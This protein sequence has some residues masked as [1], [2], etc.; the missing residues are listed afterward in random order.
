MEPGG[1]NLVFTNVI[2]Y[3]VGGGARQAKKPLQSVHN[4]PKSLVSHHTLNADGQTSAST[5]RSHA[6][7]R[8]L[9]TAR[10]CRIRRRLSAPRSCALTSGLRSISIFTGSVS[11]VRPSRRD[12]RCT[13]GSTGRP[14]SSMATLRTTLA[15]LRPTPGRVT[16]SDIL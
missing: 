14:G 15:V 11:V 7:L 5:Q 12:S 1:G 8:A 13:W 10:P 4:G 3:G 16:R 2:A 9:H 6:G